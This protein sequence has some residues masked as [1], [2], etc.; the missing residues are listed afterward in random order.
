MRCRCCNGFN[1]RT[2]SSEILLYLRG[3]ANLGT[4]PI[5]SCPVITVCFDCG[6][7]EFS[8]PGS[9]L[10]MLANLD[11]YSSEFH[12]FRPPLTSKPA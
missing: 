9:E 7:A 3:V 12:R 5:P 4:R 2:F 8:I 1:Q 11:Q 6:Y 10:R